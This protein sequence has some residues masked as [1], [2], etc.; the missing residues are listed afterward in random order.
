MTA[1][2]ASDGAS[3]P[4]NASSSSSL[5][6]LSVAS[7]SCANTTT[8]AFAESP[9]ARHALECRAGRGTRARMHAPAWAQGACL[10]LKVLTERA[11]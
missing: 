5:S 3:I 2:V 9:C 8:A 1:S 7:A 11:P 10:Q 6:A 4:R